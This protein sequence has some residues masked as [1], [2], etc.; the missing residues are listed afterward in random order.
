MRSGHLFWAKDRQATEPI[1]LEGIFDEYWGSDKHEF[2]VPSKSQSPTI[3]LTSDQEVQRS[4]PLES[5][6][7]L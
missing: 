7:G 3:P 4:L 6:V 5:I 2:K 1:D